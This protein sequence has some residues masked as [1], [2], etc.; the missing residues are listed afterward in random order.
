MEK[1]MKNLISL[2]RKDVDKLLSLMD[3]KKDI[4]I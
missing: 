2:A 1:N 3:I 4:E